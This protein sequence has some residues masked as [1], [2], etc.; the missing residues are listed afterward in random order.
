MPRR[1]RNNTI[2][3]N[4]VDLDNNEYTPTYIRISAP[5]PVDEFLKNNYYDM[6]KKLGEK[7]ECPICMEEICCKNCFTLLK[8][9]HH[10]HLHELMKCSCCPVCRQ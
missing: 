5:M 3:L 7:I 4:E 6:K 9:G 8:C 2:H 10:L 1:N